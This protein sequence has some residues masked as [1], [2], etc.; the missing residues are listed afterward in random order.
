[1]HSFSKD[2]FIHR[3][4]LVHPNNYYLSTCT[5]KLAYHHCNSCNAQLLLVVQK[6]D[7]VKLI[8]LSI[9]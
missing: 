6:M 8:A 7:Y 4:Q 9:G 1:M 2:Q 5:R 3:R